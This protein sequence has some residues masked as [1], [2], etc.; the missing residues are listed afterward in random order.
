MPFNYRW[1]CQ[2]QSALQCPGVP[3]ITAGCFI[4]LSQSRD[5]LRGLTE[6]TSGG[7]TYWLVCL[8][9]LLAG[10]DDAIKEA[11]ARDSPLARRLHTQEHDRSGPRAV[12]H[13]QPRSDAPWRSHSQ[14]LMLLWLSV[15]T[16]SHHPP[17]PSSPI[18]V[19]SFLSFS[20]L[21][22]L[23]IQQCVNTPLGRE[24]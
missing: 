8:L 10:C 16:G 17:F 12:S 5:V 21:I 19:P 11:A 6:D 24:D 14:S 2:K 4:S 15:E 18:L 20:D 22:G 9:V 1:A 23:K 7:G 3:F 13:S